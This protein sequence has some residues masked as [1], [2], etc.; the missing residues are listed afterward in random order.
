MAGLSEKKDHDDFEGSNKLLTAVNKIAALL[1]TTKDDE[2]ISIPI[3]ASME[4][5]GCSL[6][7]DRIH[8][9]TREIINDEL[10][11]RRTYSWFS[12]A[13]KNTVAPD[14]LSS[15]H[16]EI[17]NWEDTLLRGECIGGPISKMPKNDQL[18]LSAMDVKTILIIPVFLD[19]EYLG[20]F[21]VDDCKNE[22]EFT[23]DE[24]DTMCSV[25]L[26]IAS[27]VNRQALVAKRTH[28]LAVQTTT[29]TTLFDSIPGL[30]FIKNPKSEI[31]HCNK[32]FT[33]YFGVPVKDIIGKVAEDGLGVPQEVG[34][35]HREEDQ[36][37]V[38][39]NCKIKV[40]E[41]VPCFD[42]TTLLLETTK[43]PLIVDGEVAGIMGI[44][45][46]I[47]K[48]KETERLTA[49]KYAHALV[50]KDSLA[51]IMRTPEISIGDVSATAKI[52]AEQ[53]CKVLNTH[54]VSIWSLNE[55]GDTLINYSTYDS[56]TNNHSVLDDF[57][58]SSRPLYSNAIKTEW[59]VVINCIKQT[60]YDLLEEGYDYEL[61]ALL[62]APIYMGGNLVGVICA[63]QDYCDNYPK[64]REWSIE[65]QSYVSSLSDLMALSISASELRKAREDARL[66]NQA[67]ST[68]LANMSHE[69]RSP[70]NAIIGVADIIMERE[71]LP[72]DIEDELDRIYVS[73]NMLLGII[74]DILDF[75]KIEAGKLDII[76]AKYQVAGMLNDIIR[77][78]LMQMSDKQVEFEVGI[79]ENTPANL[80]GDSLRI[81]QILS[82]LLSNAFKYTE[83]G[84]VKLTIKF[85]HGKSAD[86]TVLVLIVRDTG[87]GMTKGQLASVFD[88]YLRFAH[89]TGITVGG[90]GLGLAI[91]RS[92]INLMDGKIDVD[93]RPGIGSI[94]T[95]KLPQKI[96]DDAILGSEVVNNLQKFRL[97]YITR[98]R[99]RQNEREYMPYGRVLIVDDMEPNLYVAV[100]LL[101]PYG[102][103]IETVMSGKEAIDRVKSGN[104]YDIIFMDHM[105]PEMDGIEATKHLRL[106]GYNHPIVALTANAVVG[107]SEIFLQNGFDEFISKPIDLRHLNHILIKYIRSRHSPEVVAAARKK[108]QDD[109]DLLIIDG[110]IIDSRNLEGS[111]S[112][113]SDGASNSTDGYTQS[114]NV[115]PDSDI[116]STSDNMAAD[117]IKNVAIERLSDISEIDVI[118]GLK[119]Y[120]GNVET[121][122]Q[123]LRSYAGS[124]KDRLEKVAT[125]NEDSL[126]D[127]RIHV[128]A[129]KGASFDIFANQIG[130]MAKELEDA[131]TSGDL[132]YINK[133]NSDF[134]DS[135]CRFIS[136]LNEVF[137]VMKNDSTKPKID[138]PDAK[139]LLK[140][141]DACR[142]YNLSEAEAAMKA[143]EAYRYESDDDLVE[144]L[145]TNV[146][147]MNFIEI[148]ER[149]EGE[150]HE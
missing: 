48:L 46:D 141:A 67:K 121:Y 104:V 107:Q 28:A 49:H 138:K 6:D 129:V 41:I 80:I 19:D 31:T 98:R 78:N 11:Y 40:E 76:P 100:G 61:C 63:E 96:V 112:I 2:D 77:L 56:Y 58:L 130:E 22:R 66:A 24:I 21:S 52:I 88:E 35:R 139:L 10:Q 57:D 124:V 23:Y 132:S 4:L 93:S 148:V 51:E 83:S 136:D 119:R 116:D 36:M 1:L 27:V 134:L 18:F 144:W 60:P 3:K 84:R 89:K 72:V 114:E 117:N 30:V 113:K 120:D 62:D 55:S 29:L 106:I 69:I 82:N 86:D 137:A 12:E 90:T 101:K 135:A 140:L 146:D 75:S 133:H 145:R 94:F 128:H 44:A 108:M 17:L 109:L 110:H 39:E 26:M 87:C 99:I 65:E 81:K 38:R 53:S 150:K 25:S 91:T 105:M 123:I 14:T 85:E 70:M 111:I 142:T 33:D 20:L 118:K 32:V 102:L 9:W 64:M 16:N 79:D 143:I 71:N 7:V 126:H 37:I 68:F 149:I 125:V 34:D 15:L 74:N 95:V 59:V 5:L 103:K 8:L 122:F 54:R 47:T 73:C 13:G 131:A 97:D 50:M 43:V 147:T 92:L 127:Y 115:E 42:G 45:Y